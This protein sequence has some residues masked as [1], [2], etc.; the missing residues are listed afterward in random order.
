VLYWT[1]KNLDKQAKLRDELLTI[2]P[3]RDSPLTTDNMH[4]LTYLRAFTKKAADRPDHIPSA[5][6]ANPF[7]FLPF[8][9][10]ARSCVG[11]RLAMMEMEILVSRLIRQYHVRWN[12][13]ELK[14]KASIVNVLATDLKFELKDVKD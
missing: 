9:F 6:D 11:K 7:I 12:Y 1:A 13:G 3:S 10:R 4:N 8:G 14:F 2:L 5:K